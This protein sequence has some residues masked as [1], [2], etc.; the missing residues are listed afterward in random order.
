MLSGKLIEYMATGVPVLSLGKPNSEAGRLLDLGTAAKMIDK[1]DTSNILAFLEKAEKRKG[2][3]INSFPQKS[4]LSRK[5]TTQNL[6]EAL[7]T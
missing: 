3:W 6:I 2:K 1:D 4:N 5:G 7:F